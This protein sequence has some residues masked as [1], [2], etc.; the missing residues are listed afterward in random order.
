MSEQDA[1]KKSSFGPAFFF[2]GRQKRNALAH[3]YN[4]CR[5]ADDTVDEPNP[6]AQQTL[7]DLAAEVEYIYLG[8]PKTQWGEDLVED[9]RTFS[10]DKNRFLLL[11]EGM[12]ADLDQRKYPTFESL[13]W[14]LYRVAVIVG[15]A[16]LDILNVRGEKADELAQSL[17]TAVQLTNIVR[18]VHED[19]KLGRVYLPCALSAQDILEHKKPAL[20]QETCQQLTQLAQEQYTRAFQLM[21]DFWPVT[22]IPCRVMGYV[23]QKNLAKIEE[24]GFKSE[25]SV[26]LTKFEKMQMVAYALIKTLF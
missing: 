11:L 7:K 5:I 3:Y 24:Q 6:N 9:V 4:F 25:T 8:A 13:Q 14:Y 18:D 22:M 20:V 21:D 16:T 17:G 1:Y 15:K 10:I 26:K 2:L 23:Y 12:Q 19:A